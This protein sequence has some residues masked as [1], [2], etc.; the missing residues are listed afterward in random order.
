MYI[1]FHFQN[2]SNIKI[3]QMQVDGKL[4]M[5]WCNFADPTGS[6]MH[7]NWLF[8]VLLNRPLKRRRNSCDLMKCMST[9]D[10]DTYHLWLQQTF[11]YWMQ[12][13]G[14]LV[15]RQAVEVKCSDFW[16]V[17]L[18][19]KIHLIP[20]KDHQ[21]LKKYMDPFESHWQCCLTIP[22]QEDQVTSG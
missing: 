9:R 14:N 17:H 13:E 1:Q 15:W 11:G 21:V 20:W 5:Q 8:Q 22:S 3:C 7:L 10:C 2:S 6:R 4:M 12:E 19:S 18:W 16:E